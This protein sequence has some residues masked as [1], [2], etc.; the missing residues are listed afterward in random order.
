LLKIIFWRKKIWL[1]NRQFLATTHTF[2]LLNNVCHLHR[3]S[4]CEQKSG[5]FK[6]I[7]L[8]YMKLCKIC[9]ICLLQRLQI[10]K[11]IVKNGN[12]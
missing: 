6:R 7:L 1:I 11:K 8:G 9:I 5:W 3:I 10:A 2:C 12:F 4:N